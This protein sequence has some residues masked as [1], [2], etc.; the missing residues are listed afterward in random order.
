MDF[1][2]LIK[3][4]FEIS[5]HNRVLW[6]FGFLSGGATSAAY[7]NPSGFNFTLPGSE[8]STDHATKVLG[9]IDPSTGLVSSQAMLLIILAIILIVLIIFLAAIFV[10]NWAAGALVFS[11]LERNK[12]RPTFSAG[13]HS[14]LKYWWKFWLLTLILGLLV[15]AFML[16]LAIPAILLFLGNLSSLAIVYLVLA[17]FVFIIAIFVISAIGSLIISIAQRMII[18]KNV[19]VIDSIRLSGGLIKKYL[20]ESL[21]AYVIDVGLN[22]AASFVALIVLLPI[23]IILFLLFLAGMAANLFIWPALIAA[24]PALIL[25]FAASGFWQSFN[26]SYW[27]LFYEYLASKEGW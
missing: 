5:W 23:G 12:Q 11:I 15:L 13:A 2:A 8:K 7:L 10:S 26:A 19:G 18:H 9:I 25:L 6:L 14:G 17:V 1:A 24:I 22:F 3:K 16:M 21:L 4:S 27:T 20:G